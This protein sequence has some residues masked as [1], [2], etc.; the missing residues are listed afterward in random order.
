MGTLLSSFETLLAFICCAPHMNG[1]NINAT[2]DFVHRINR[3]SP[4]DAYKVQ[5]VWRRRARAATRRR[6]RRSAA[7]NAHRRGRAPRLRARGR[8]RPPRPPR[9]GTPIAAPSRPATP[10]T[11][12]RSRR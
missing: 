12:S 3:T 5:E 7:A 8:S 11:L 6:A 10:A 2:L 9:T 1:H 4:T